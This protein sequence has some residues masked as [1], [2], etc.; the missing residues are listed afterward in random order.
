MEDALKRFA[1]ERL[2]LFYTS[3]IGALAAITG[4]LLLGWLP[5]RGPRSH[6]FYRAFSPS[7]L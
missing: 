4:A 1:G 7:L 2:L 5:P 3:F 6:I